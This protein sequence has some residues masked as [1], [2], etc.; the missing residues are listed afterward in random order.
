MVPV[1]YDFCF[2]PAAQCLF[3]CHGPCSCNNL[4]L[5]VREDMNRGV[6]V[7]RL[8]EP[9]VFSLTEAF[10]VLFTVNRYTHNQNS[11][12]HSGPVVFL[13]YS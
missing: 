13:P 2:L 6:Y 8:S 7:E 12:T 4:I 10:Q 5:K 3:S 1:A 11:Q 9:T